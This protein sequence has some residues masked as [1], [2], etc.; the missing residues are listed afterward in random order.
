MKHLSFLSTFLLLTLFSNFSAYAQCDW[1]DVD[2][3]EYVQDIDTTKR[4]FVYDHNIP[5]SLVKYLESGSITW[6]IYGGVLENKDDFDEVKFKTVYGKRIQVVVFS[7]AD[8]TPPVFP[9]AHVFWPKG[10]YDRQIR[11]TLNANGKFLSCKVENKTYDFETK[12]WTNLPPLWDPQPEDTTADVAVVTTPPAEKKVIETMVSFPPIHYDYNKATIRPDAAKV[13]DQMVQVLKDNPHIKVELAA[14]TDS[15]GSASYNKT[16]SQRR[17]DAAVNYILSKGIA[18]DRIT[19][20]GYGESE[21]LKLAKAE[22]G[23]NAGTT[24]NDSKVNTLSAKQ[25]E[26]AHQL[27]RRTEFRVVDFVGTK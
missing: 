21:P 27:N 2:I 3:T 15:R 9:Q 7:T 8:K 14:H 26:V 11:M 10:L 5:D 17:A 4:K 25:Q 19:A 22:S 18:K 23:F 1:A 20:K 13:L 16:L 24:L 6:E 12:D